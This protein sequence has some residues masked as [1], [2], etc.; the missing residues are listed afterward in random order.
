MQK[1]NRIIVSDK[2]RERIISG[3]KWVFR[4]DIAEDKSDNSDI[5]LIFDK[6]RHLLGTA[7]YSRD[8]QIALRLMSTDEI[9]DVAKHIENSLDSAIRYRKSL[10]LTG[11]CMRIIHSEADNLP[12]LIID[13]YSDTIVF[14]ILTRPMENLKDIVIQKIVNTLNPVQVFE[15]NDSGTRDIEKLP[16]ILQTVYG[17]KRDNL[18][19]TENHLVFYADL[20]NSQ[21]T[22]EFLDQ[23]INRF[24]LGQ[25]GSGRVLD[26][27]CYHGWFGCNIR[28]YSE[29][30][31]ADS[32]REALRIA[33]INLKLNQKKNF[34]VKEI[35]VFD[36]LRTLDKQNESFDTIILDPPGFIKS[37]KDLRSGYSGYKEINLR[38]MKIL[39][40]D[41][42]LATF[43]CSYYMSNEEFLNM[44]RDAAKD[45]KAEFIIETSL[46]QSPDHRELLGFPESHYLKGYLLRKVN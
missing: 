36:F 17:T 22:S 34:S 14:Q 19:C 9:T 18:F 43:S 3:H 44:L 29:L 21:K 13:K 35:N 4:S 40:R 39:K 7:L 26:L 11:D 10:N 41:G 20:I 2:G 31:I 15:K 32:S 30:I 6:K 24:I 1:T 8:S 27:F 16:K 25:R 33:E 45:A 23:K 37:K 28:N 42:I 5:V 12:G 38:A 46:S